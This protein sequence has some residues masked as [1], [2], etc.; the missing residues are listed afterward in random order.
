[1]SLRVSET[2]KKECN[3]I[4]AAYCPQLPVPV[5]RSCII[6]IGP[7]DLDKLGISHF[8]FGQ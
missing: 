2:V 4:S 6:L 7:I 5:A 8:D 3:T 1:M